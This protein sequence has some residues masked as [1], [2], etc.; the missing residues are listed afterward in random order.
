MTDSP[1]SKFIQLQNFL[2]HYFLEKYS[3]SIKMAKQVNV[4]DAKPDDWNLIPGAY[5][6]E[7]ND[8]LLHVVL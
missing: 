7:A 5:V 4:L 8:C 3:L 1:M 6:V 2:G